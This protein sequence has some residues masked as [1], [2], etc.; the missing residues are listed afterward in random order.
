M[1]KIQLVISS[2]CFLSL[3]LHIRTI[4][5]KTYFLLDEF[6]VNLKYCEKSQSN[7]KLEAYCLLTFISEQ[8]HF[9]LLG[10]FALRSYIF[11]Q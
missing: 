11:I 9:H 10:K 7:K 6:Q 5:L 4:I 1:N 2:Y 8:L 3:K